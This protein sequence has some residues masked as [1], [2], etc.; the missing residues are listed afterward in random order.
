MKLSPKSSYLRVVCW[1][2]CYGVAARS[3][4]CGIHYISPK[5]LRLNKSFS[6]YDCICDIEKK[7][8]EIPWMPRKCRQLHRG[9]QTTKQTHLNK[10]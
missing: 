8:K 1:G 3:G 9:S 6:F 4:A 2:L 5:T 7:N 10:N